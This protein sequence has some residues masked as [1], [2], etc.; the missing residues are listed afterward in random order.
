[1]DGTP[2][3]AAGA[4]PVVTL[5]N[6][7]DN[8]RAA[9]RRFAVVFGA[10]V[11]LPSSRLRP[12]EVVSPAAP[13]V[14]ALWLG[15]YPEPAD[16][17]DRLAG[18]AEDLTA[19]RFQVTVVPDIHRWKAAKLVSNVTNALDALYA[20]SALRSAAAR[21]VRAEA[22]AVLNA[23][24]LRPAELDP[25]RLRQVVVAQPVPGQEPVRSSTWQ[26]LTMGGP[27]ETDFLNGEVVLAAR[28]LGVPR[29]TTPRW[30]SAW[31]RAAAEAT[32]PGSLTDADLTAT[33]PTLTR[34]DVLIDA[35]ELAELIQPGRR[36]D[37]A[38]RALGAR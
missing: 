9:L 5:Q 13:T 25:A 27:P 18:I 24:G 10:L 19:A 23:A 2:S 36:A 38:R 4:L 32:A 20:P 31:Q 1:V 17:D 14:G 37:A 30:P 28:L 29:P 15:R 26:S 11:W 12:A 7:L 34:R 16:A 8:E 6:G 22:R 33:L 21:A 3:T 35:A